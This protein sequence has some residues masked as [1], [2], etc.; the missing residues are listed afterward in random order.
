M[1]LQWSALRWAAVGGVVAASVA[2]ARGTSYDSPAFW[3]VTLYSSTAPA[4]DGLGLSRQQRAIRNNVDHGSTAQKVVL[5]EKA[6]ANE[7]EEGEAMVAQQFPMSSLV[8]CERAGRE[9]AHAFTL[10]SQMTTARYAC[11][12][13]R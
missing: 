10:P 13:G 5:I 6:R 4:E 1:L 9:I 7:M 12:R 3:L 11:V 8:A 2:L